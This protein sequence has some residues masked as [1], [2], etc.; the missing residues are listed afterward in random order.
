METVSD[1]WIADFDGDGL[2]ELAL[3]R[4]PVRNPTQASGIVEK[5]VSYESAPKSRSILLVSVLNDGIDFHSAFVE[6]RRL[7]PSDTEVTPPGDVSNYL[8]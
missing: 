1:E 4:L 8:W 5:I 6:V 3:G 2:A 7:V